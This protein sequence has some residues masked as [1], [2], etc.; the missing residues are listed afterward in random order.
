[1]GK[2]VE[3]NEWWQ[4]RIADQ[5]EGMEYGS[6]VITVHDGRIVQIDRTERKRF[7]PSA[8]AVPA[9]KAGAEQPLKGVNPSLK[10]AGKVAN[11]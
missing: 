6:V 1:M 11:G 5:L 9:A 10:A 2:Q 7:D 3:L 8:G 4:D